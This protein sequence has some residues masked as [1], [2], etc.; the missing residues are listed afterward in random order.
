MAA[1]VISQPMPGRSSGIT[2]APM[3]PARA[4][5]GRTPGGRATRCQRGGTGG[6]GGGMAIADDLA[7]QAAA[8]AASGS[9]W[10]VVRL[11]ASKGANGTESAGIRVAGDAASGSGAVVSV[12]TAVDWVP[13][14]AAPAS[15]C[16]SLPASEETPES[17]TIVVFAG[18]SADFPDPVVQVPAT[19]FPATASGGET[20]AVV[21]V[22]C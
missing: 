17:G 2:V 5:A 15:T 18:S 1:P 4:A 11:A 20:V 9:G 19:A 16:E 21:S 10:T 7:G 3:I 13:G 14:L 6:M 12:S 8:R 22:P